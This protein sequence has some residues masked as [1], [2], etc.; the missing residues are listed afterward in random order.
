ML[1][2][3]TVGQSVVAMLRVFGNFEVT[4]G[5]Q[6]KCRCIN[7]HRYPMTTY[8]SSLPSEIPIPEIPEAL[9]WENSDE[10]KAATAKGVSGTTTAQMMARNRHNDRM[11]DPTIIGFFKLLNE[12]KFSE[13]KALI[14]SEEVK[15]NE[16]LPNGKTVLH[17][18]DSE[19]EHIVFLL[20][21]GANP[22]LSE[23]EEFDED[24]VEYAGQLS[25]YGKTILIRAAQAGD[26][27]LIG[28]L[29]AFGANP[30]KTW[31]GLT[32]YQ[33]CLNARDG[34]V[35]DRLRMLVARGL[36][37]QA[38]HINFD[39]SAEMLLFKME[40]ALLEEVVIAGSVL[41]QGKSKS[42]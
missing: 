25:R 6:F 21:C 7:G 31:N 40:Q 26:H 11:G 16:Y 24:E 8:F 1:V 22:N 15:L 17:L 18:A 12:G 39:L 32:P 29:L 4:D 14:D 28:L 23:Y 30:N 35:G 34:D 41:P 3:G 9:R 5:T 2:R 37:A 19:Y 38:S 33:C 36:G 10:F 27:K 42:V 20:R 13:A